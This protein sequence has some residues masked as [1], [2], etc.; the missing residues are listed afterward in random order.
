MIWEVGSKIH[1]FL[2]SIETPVVRSSKI[3]VYHTFSKRVKH[4]L[5]KASGGVSLTTPTQPYSYKS[6]SSDVLHRP[7]G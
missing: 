4:G 2:V 1:R 3:E 6:P 5:F 7:R